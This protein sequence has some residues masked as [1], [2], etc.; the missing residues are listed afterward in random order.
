MRNFI[1]GLSDHILTVC[2]IIAI[3]IATAG[4]ST[5][6]GRGIVLTGYGFPIPFPKPEIFKITSDPSGAEVYF[7]GKLMGTTPIDSNRLQI[8]G[9]IDETYKFTAELPDHEF[10][11]VE[12][13]NSSSP[14]SYKNASISKWGIC[15]F[16]IEF[17]LPP[18]IQ[19]FKKAEELYRA[20]SYAEAAEIYRK[21]I[22]TK[23]KIKFKDKSLM[24]IGS[25]YTIQGKFDKATN[26]YQ[27]LISEYPDSIYASRA[28]LGLIYNEYGRHNYEEAL[29]K[30]DLAFKKTDENDHGRIY[31]LKGDILLALNKVQES[32]VA[33]ANAYEIAAQNELPIIFTRAKQA[34]SVLKSYELKYLINIYKRR[35]PIVYLLFQQAK[36][37]VESGNS[38]KGLELLK[39]IIDDYPDHEMIPNIVEYESYAKEKLSKVVRETLT[40]PPVLKIDCISF[41]KKVLN[42]LETANLNITL[43]NIGPGE[44]RD[45]EAIVST[46]TK[47]IVIPNKI[48]FPLIKAKNGTQTISVPVTASMNVPN[49][50][51]VLNIQIIDPHFNVK[52]KG[53][54]LFFSTRAFKKP[55]L[56][57]VRFAVMENVSPNNNQQIDINEIIDVKLAV[58]NLGKGTAELIEIGIQNTQKGLKFLG[59]VDKNSNTVESPIQILKILPG[60]YETITYRYFINSELTDNKIYF[61]LW[62]R[63]KYD[64]YGFNIEKAVPV[65]RKLEAEGFIK[66]YSSNDLEKEKDFLIEDVPNFIADIDKTLPKTYM[67]N[68]SAVAIVIGNRD[69]DKTNSVQYAIND[70]LSIKR[71]LAEVLGYQESN[72]ELIKNAS[73]GDFE[74]Y[75]GTSDDFQGK[76]YNY[77]GHNR[78]PDVFIYYSGHGAYGKKTNKSF[79]V[80]VETDPQYPE[81]GGYPTD[82]FY[83]NLNHVQAKSFTIILDCCFSGTKQVSPM[84]QRWDHNRIKLPNATL[85]TSSKGRQYSSWY[86]EKNHSLFTY[87]LL[88]GIHSKEADFNLDNRISLKEL[89]KY[90]S[91]RSNGVP[92]YSRRLN[93]IDQTPTMS[94][95]G[96]RILVIYK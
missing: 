52:I 39:N 65:N 5:K 24:K 18:A 60:K 91:N 26:I 68:L 86:P 36:L 23:I 90:V 1:I 64:K 93:N 31:I 56:Q 11:Y 7:N 37:L 73:K 15:E 70:A 62:A 32:I 35:F 58:Q 25:I 13:L 89:F 96:N 92:Y 57:L 16:Q 84:I 55:D 66:P 69:Y 88:K 8:F 74:T 22:N 40:L 27:Q 50:H 77:V 54:K 33:Y 42:C 51:S 44:A 95:D 30:I 38:I 49:S 9:T 72:I 17:K 28:Q 94:G 19:L 29:K 83:K 76:L 48:K 71:Y 67:E 61:N 41:S 85:F 12:G 21:Y 47:G 75:F 53:K 34:V 46:E 4:C 63:E 59:R 81:L 14:S 2:L 80:P 79:F 6:A 20:R 10:G 87:F 82:I 78:E 45:I 43:K 3:L